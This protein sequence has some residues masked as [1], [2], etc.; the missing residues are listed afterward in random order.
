MIRVVKPPCLGT[1]KF[2]LD[3]ALSS[4]FWLL[5]AGGWDWVTFKGPSQL[6]QFYVSVIL[7]NNT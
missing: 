5:T 3:E 1:F 7:D 2:K 4:L 6:K